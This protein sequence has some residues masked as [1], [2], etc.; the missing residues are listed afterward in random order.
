MQLTNQTVG[1]T[2]IR[3]DLHWML[4]DD[5]GN[6]SFA[7]TPP[8]GLNQDFIDLADAMAADWADQVLATVADVSHTLKRVFI[9]AGE[10]E[11]A[12]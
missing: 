5:E 9:L 10:N 1:V 8:G 4:V 7:I 12:L 2:E 3:Y 11:A 6:A